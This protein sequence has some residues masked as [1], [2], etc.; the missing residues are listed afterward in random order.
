MAKSKTATVLSIETGA[1]T[2]AAAPVPAPTLDV[3]LD[4]I[5][6]LRKGLSGIIGRVDARQ[7]DVESSQAGLVERLYAAEEL[8]VELRAQVEFYRSEAEF[9]HAETRVLRAR[10]AAQEALADTRWWERTRRRQI[11]R[12]LLVELGALRQP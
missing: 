3:A 4:R 9:A 12:G 8:L 7:S 2:E 11:N 10:V 1:P 6:S 5:E